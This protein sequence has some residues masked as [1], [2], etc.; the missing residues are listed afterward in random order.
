M[1]L[2]FAVCGRAQYGYTPLH[3]AASNGQLECARLLLE[4]GVDKNVK[5]DV[6]A[7]T[8]LPRRAASELFSTL[9]YSFCAAPPL[10]PPLLR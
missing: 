4:R 7:P 9:Y 6:R 2:S 3:C 8:P 1:T 10:C 5:V